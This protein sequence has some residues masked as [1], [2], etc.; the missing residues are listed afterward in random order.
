[1]FFGK[2]LAIV[3]ISLLSLVAATPSVTTHGHTNGERIARGHTIKGPKRLYDPSKVNGKTSWQQRGNMAYLLQ[4][5][6]PGD[7]ALR[8]T[9]PKSMSRSQPMG[10]LPSVM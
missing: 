7:L 2:R 10:L 5:H 3:A 9:R 1:M 6:Q 4:H 8:E